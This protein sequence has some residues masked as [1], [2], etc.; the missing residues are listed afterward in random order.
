MNTFY[1]IVFE[2]LIVENISRRQNYVYPKSLIEWKSFYLSK[3]PVINF[4]RFLDQMSNTFIFLLK[5]LL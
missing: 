4:T 1:K 2:K 3:F 5:S